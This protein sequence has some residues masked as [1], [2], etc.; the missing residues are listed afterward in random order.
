MSETTG[1]ADMNA[2]V[3]ED[4]RANGGA[5]DEAAGGFFAGKP[6]LILHTSGAKTGKER[7]H[8]LVYA[9]QEDRLVVAASKGGAPT[10]PH[11]FLNLRANPDVTVEVGTETFSARATIVAP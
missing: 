1:P 4:F 9:T 5:V 11:W 3:I 2:Q 8:P 10:H 6:V 7:L